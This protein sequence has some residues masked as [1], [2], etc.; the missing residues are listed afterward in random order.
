MVNQ[1]LKLNS[2]SKIHQKFHKKKKGENN[3]FFSPSS[4]TIFLI[5]TYVCYLKIILFNIDI[6][7]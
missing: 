4:L 5:I 2:S 6:I 7:I 3:L 1:S